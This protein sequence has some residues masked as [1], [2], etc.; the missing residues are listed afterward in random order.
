MAKR[1]PGETWRCSACQCPLI[2]AETKEGRTAPI[3]FNPHDEGNVLIFKGKPGTAGEGKLLARTF[4]GGPLKALR[5]QGVT[6]RRNHFASCPSA[7]HFRHEAGAIAQR[8]TDE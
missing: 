2:G 5:E 1:K 8:L 4:S 7:E 3:E 6:L